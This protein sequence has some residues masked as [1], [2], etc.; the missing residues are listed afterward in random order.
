MFIFIAN[1]HSSNIKILNAFKKAGHVSLLI[2]SI[3]SNN[4]SCHIIQRSEIT[5][6]CIKSKI[7]KFSKLLNQVWLYINAGASNQH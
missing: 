3:N 6:E 1:T 2:A 4:S 7:S 5:A